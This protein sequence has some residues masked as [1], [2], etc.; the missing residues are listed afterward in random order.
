MTQE[1]RRTVFAVAISL[2]HAFDL[3]LT[4]VW[5]AVDPR[6]SP[7]YGGVGALAHAGHVAKL[8]QKKSTLSV[9]KWICCWRLHLCLTTTV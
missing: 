1:V 8:P 5:H 9:I 6:F 7:T 2:Q 4:H 3:L